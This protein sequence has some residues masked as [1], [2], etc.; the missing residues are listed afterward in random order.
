MNKKKENTIYPAKILVAGEF[1]VL[2][3]GEALAIPLRKYFSKWVLKDSPDTRLETLINPLSNL[4]SIDIA[5]FTDDIRNGW[6]LESNIPIGYGLG[7]SGAVSAAILDRYGS[8]TDSDQIGDIKDALASI[9]NSFHGTSSGFDPL[10]SY[11]NSGYLMADKHLKP[12]PIDH[13]L[14]ESLSSFYLID[15]L[16]PR[17][18]IAPIKWFYD[19]LKIEKFH[20]MTLKLNELNEMFIHAILNLEKQATHEYFKMISG[21]QLDY[22][23]PLITSNLIDYW[24]HGLDTDDYYLKLCGKGGG[25][26]YLLYAGS[27]SKIKEISLP[28]SPIF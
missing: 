23:K 15:S 16:T 21:L 2:Q 25:G 26:F 19:S 22:F 13:A 1:T 18:T 12:I 8:K 7:S 4:N 14:E 10:I 24:N 3:G 6:Q 17:N 28:V 9:E 5:G 20:S 11:T 27:P